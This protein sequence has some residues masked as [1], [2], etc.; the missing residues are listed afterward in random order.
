MLCLTEF[1][2][3]KIL[4]DCGFI[5]PKAFLAKNANSTEK[6]AKK[7]GY[8]VV[9]KIM[10]SD[11]VHKSDYGCVKTGIT[12]RSEAKFAYHAIIN[13]ALNRNIAAKIDGVSVEETLSGVELIVGAKQDPQF[14]PIILFGIGGVFVE[15]LKDAAIRL[16]PIKRKDAKEMISEIKG[17]KLLEGYRGMPQ[18]NLAAVEDALLAASK[19]I[20]KHVEIMEMDINPLFANEKKAVVG[21]ARIIIR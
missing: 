7:I 21:D 4:K 13:N 19:L 9:L 20:C 10:S 14:G 16:A 2:S 12:N 3:R 8:P 5:L 11:I 1:K 18:V 15:I 6:Y 17:H